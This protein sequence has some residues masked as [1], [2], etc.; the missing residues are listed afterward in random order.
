M[1][2]ARPS[3]WKFAA[4]TPLKS[5]LCSFVI[6]MRFIRRVRS[7]RPENMSSGSS[8]ME[9]APKV[10]YSRSRYLRSCGRS[11]VKFLPSRFMPLASASQFVWDVRFVFVTIAVLPVEQP[12][13]PYVPS[14]IVPPLE[15][16]P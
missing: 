3:I 9:L 16:E 15:T 1:L 7:G 5:L 10:R 13:A 4:L 12:N 14:V 2:S 8:E 6:P 11:S